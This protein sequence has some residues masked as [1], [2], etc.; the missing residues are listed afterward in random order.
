MKSAM[1]AESFSMKAGVISVWWAAATRWNH[2]RT[3]ASLAAAAAFVLAL[4]AM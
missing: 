4:D 1:R 2:V 3:V